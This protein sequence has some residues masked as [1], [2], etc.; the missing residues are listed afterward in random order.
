M[1]SSNEAVLGI[2]GSLR[3]ASFNRALLATLAMR[4]PAGL[5][6]RIYDDLRTIPLFDEDLESDGGP[7][8]V[9]RLRE[10]VA[11][12][13]GILIATPEYNQSLPGVVKNL[14]D[15]LSRSRP[16]VL[17]GK[18]VG[19]VGTT[20]GPWGT[21]L[22]QAALRQTLTACGALVMPAPQVYLPNAACAFDERAGR[23]DARTDELLRQFL[24]AFQKWIPEARS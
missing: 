17:A 13:P 19:I 16:E 23:I 5:Q 1:R 8:A 10:E 22:A 12:A 18:A 3:K 9:A 4:A 6:I 11:R 24:E 7:A 14:V 20:P 2:A 21:R 15:W